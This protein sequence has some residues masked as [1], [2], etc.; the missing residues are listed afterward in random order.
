MRHS[1]LVAV[2][3]VAIAAWMLW[4]VDERELVR[5]LP[6][7]AATAF[8]AGHIS[9]CLDAF[10]A[11]FSDD[12]DGRRIDRETIRAALLGALR[13]RGDAGLVARVEDE[14]AIVDEFDATAGTARVRCEVALSRVSPGARY[15][16]AADEIWTV[17]IDASLRR[18]DDGTWRFVR[19]EH[20]TLSG[21][22]PYR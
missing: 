21:Q 20:R 15:V 17:A 7:R 11:E 4:P 5:H 16:A 3:V 6:M 10:D 14:T 13:G 9:D 12:S 19:A 8:S 1:L 18:A 2:P 22:A